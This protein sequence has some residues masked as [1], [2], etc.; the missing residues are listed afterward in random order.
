ME[1]NTVLLKEGGVNVALTIVDTPG[2][3][4]SVDNSNFWKPILAYLESQFEAFLKAGTMVNRKPALQDSRVDA[5]LCI[6]APSG[7]NDRP[8]LVFIILFIPPTGRGLKNLDLE[9][10]SNS[11]PLQSRRAEPGGDGRI[12]A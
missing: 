12:E 4:D 7:N 1:T 6:I 3:G 2:F 10:E 8:P 11:C 9:G 5:V